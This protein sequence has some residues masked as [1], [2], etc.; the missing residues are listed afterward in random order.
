MIFTIFIASIS[1]VT[2]ASSKNRFIFI[3]LRYN[4]SD[5]TRCKSKI[6]S[7]MIFERQQPNSMSSFLYC[8]NFPH[9]RIN[10]DGIFRLKGR[11]RC[12]E[13]H[14]KLQYELELRGKSRDVYFTKAY[15]MK[16]Y[17]SMHSAVK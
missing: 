8:M 2:L 4:K 17:I 5:V 16:I 10:S 6:E 1:T 9:T 11:P 12:R 7:T 13:A 3:I 15:C 14:I